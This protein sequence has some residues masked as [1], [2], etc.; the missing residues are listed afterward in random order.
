AFR[1]ANFNLSSRSRGTVMKKAIVTL[2]LIAVVGV[3][4]WQAW[5]RYQ[6]KQQANNG[7]QRRGGG[8]AV[9]VEVTASSRRT[10]VDARVFAGTLEPNSQF[11]VAPKVS[12]RLATLAVDLGDA[13]KPGEP[14][15]TLDADE[16]EQ[17][18][19]Q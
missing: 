15:A 11:V 3:I 1:R 10:L 13:V 17:D 14:I 7:Q 4:G 9:A 19:K 5:Q 18:V 16:Y 2:V 6:A 12:G 8:G